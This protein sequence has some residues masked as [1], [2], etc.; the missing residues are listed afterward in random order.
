MAATSSVPAACFTMNPA[1]PARSVSA[2]SSTSACIVKTMTLVAIPSVLSR[3]STS[4][5]LMP[6]MVMSVTTTSGRNCRTAFRSWEPSVTVATTEN[7]LRRRLASPS[8]TTAWSSAS[9]TVA[10]GILEFRHWHGDPELG[11]ALRPTGDRQAPTHETHPLV[12]TDQAQA[13]PVPS[14]GGI[15][16]AA[17]VPDRQHHVPLVELHRHGRVPRRRMPGDVAQALLC[18]PV[19]AQGHV[20]RHHT[21][22]AVRPE[23]HLE[24]LLVAER[25]A[26]AAQCRDEPGVLEDPGME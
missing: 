10:R 14:I 25:A 13:V 6:G 1:A 26:V 20:R 7:S 23:R 15:E 18:H 19:E 21:E 16:A 24:I 8:A 22:L 17:V 2:A 5:P 4:S 11:A 12:E 9:S 3:R